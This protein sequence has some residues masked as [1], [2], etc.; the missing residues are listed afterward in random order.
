MADDDGTLRTFRMI[1]SIIAGILSLVGS[2]L[3]IFTILR[4]KKKL[5][6]PY[7]RI[8]FG[9]CVLDVFQSL[10]ST[11]SIFLSPKELHIH[12]LSIGNVTTCD[13][14]GL[15]LTIGAI[16]VPMYLCSLCTYYFCIIRLNMR[17]L[18]FK[19]I[20][21]YLHTVP[22]LYSLFC[23]VF[24]LT[25]KY[26]NNA[27]LVCYVAPDPITC[28]IIPEEKCTRGEGATQFR[29]NFL[30]FPTMAIFVI[31]CT[32][33]S[34]ITHWVRKLETRR[35]KYSFPRS[36]QSSVQLGYQSEAS[37][38]G[39]VED[40]HG[41]LSK[42]KGHQLLGLRI[43]N[44]IF[45]WRSPSSSASNDEGSAR[46]NI[47]A[48]ASHSPLP[49]HSVSNRRRRS[50]RTTD[51]TREIGTQAFLYIGSYVVSY[52]FVW[53]QQLYNVVLKKPTPLAISVLASIFFPLQG[54]INMF[55]YCRPH[56]VS[57]QKDFPDEYNW[58]QAFVRV[59]KSGGDDPLTPQERR[60]NSMHR[61]RSHHSF[62][63]NNSS[64]NPIEMDNNSDFG[65]S[66]SL[67]GLELKDE[68][69][70]KRSSTSFR[71]D[72]ESQ[73]GE[74]PFRRPSY[75]FKPGYHFDSNYHFKLSKKLDSSE[76]DGGKENNLGIPMGIMDE[77]TG[78]ENTIPE[79]SVPDES[80]SNCC[81][82]SE[83][84]NCRSKSFR[85]NLREEDYWNGDDS[86]ELRKPP[87]DANGLSTRTTD[88]SS[89]DNEV[90]VKV[91]NGKC[92]CDDASSVGS[93][94]E[95]LQNIVRGAE[96]VIDET[97]DAFLAMAGREENRIN[98]DDNAED[99]D[100]VTAASTVTI[101]A[102]LR[103][104]IDTATTS[105][106]S[107]TCSHIVDHEERTLNQPIAASTTA[108]RLDDG[109][110][111]VDDQDTTT[112]REASDA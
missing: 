43:K 68:M 61:V 76:S 36:T 87:Q 11:S 52:G 103:N 84:D 12:R 107:R 27:G 96:Q 9:I 47:P 2:S 86:D 39:G 62:Q 45:F 94:P 90:A 5:S 71:T 6:V 64:N 70:G 109:P 8:I 89:S 81:P 78:N 24:A 4:S 13:I 48:E 106:T 3:L 69:F 35:K 10:G 33:M 30:T 26:I 34:V 29:V 28:D 95:S 91:D 53:A 38:D 56:I 57:L 105:N 104:I 23:G 17:K 80:S 100:T 31:V 18:T 74:E 21:P 75:Q 49:T 63:T 44:A 108:Q 79:V 67:P 72:S 112:E 54:F 60:L 102:P 58:F 66:H 1:N 37:F 55:V 16:G 73:S 85:P 19:K 99:F 111:I 98:C 20:E 32:T 15:F 83:F 42:K 65:S 92:N 97:L 7:R 110:V 101:N 25:N 46:N 50:H 40:P 88:D 59:L 77:T 41:R 14:Q 22:I 93:V 82:S 51:R